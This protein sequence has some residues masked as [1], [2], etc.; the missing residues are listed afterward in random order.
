MPNNETVKNVTYAGT[1]RVATVER[2]VT[3]S[4]DLEQ[5]GN[6]YFRLS[7]IYRRIDAAVKP[8]TDELVALNADKARIQSE[9]ETYKGYLAGY[10]NT[11]EA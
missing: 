3:R 11:Q 4:E 5:L 9:I 2:T 7:D 1:T 6:L 8:G 10:E